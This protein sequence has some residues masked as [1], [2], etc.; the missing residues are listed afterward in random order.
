MPLRLAFAWHS[1]RPHDIYRIIRTTFAVANA[2]S[3]TFLHVN[4]SED[5]VAAMDIE[6]SGRAW[7]GCT[8]CVRIA[9]PQ[10]TGCALAYGK[11]S[12]FSRLNRVPQAGHG[13]HACKQYPNGGGQA[14]GCSPA[15]HIAP[16]CGKLRLAGTRVQRCR[17]V[18]LSG[19][20]A[21][22]TRL[23]KGATSRHARL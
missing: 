21:K 14:P 15:M 6:R 16:W 20:L 2:D 1:W 3:D 12:S 19:G 11:A 18:I 22:Q 9:V 13:C 10:S 17:S 7:T 23:K 8:T 5:S 4:N